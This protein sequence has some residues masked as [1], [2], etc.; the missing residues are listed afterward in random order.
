MCLTDAAVMVSTMAI[1]QHQSCSV[2][3]LIVMQ[4]SLPAD[5]LLCLSCIPELAQWE[6]GAFSPVRDLLR[7]SD[8]IATSISDESDSC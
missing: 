2:D 1:T 6:S 7:A 3:H 5:D 8:S 4:C